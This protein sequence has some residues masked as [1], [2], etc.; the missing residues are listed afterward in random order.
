MRYCKNQRRR[1][2]FGFFGTLPRD[3]HHWEGGVGEAKKKKKIIPQRAMQQVVFE[4][5]VYTPYQAAW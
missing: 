2:Y 4:S 3:C 5:A 1:L